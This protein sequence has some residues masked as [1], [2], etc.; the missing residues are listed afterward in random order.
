MA[1][2][3]RWASTSMLQRIVDDGKKRLGAAKNKWAVCYGPGAA[4]LMT[5]ERIGW[6]VL[7]ATKLVTHLG[8]QLNLVLDPPKWSLSWSARL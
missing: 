8:V 3:E 7:T 5:C 6:T 1:V 4:M 2:W